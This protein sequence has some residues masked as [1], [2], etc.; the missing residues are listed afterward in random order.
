M[1]GIGRRDPEREGPP[2][3]EP[4]E[5]LRAKY[6]DYCSAQLAEV[7]LRLSP[8]EIFLLAQ[9]AAGSGEGAPTFG[10][11]VQRVTAELERRLALPPFHV[12][13]DDYRRHPERYDE[14]LLGL[15]EDGVEVPAE[16]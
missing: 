6:F 10:E 13:A 8:D 14:Y 12:W 4:E 16:G 3:A 15:W 1:P 7:F 11:L 2:G 5:V 9:E